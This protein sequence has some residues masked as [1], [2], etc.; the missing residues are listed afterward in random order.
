MVTARVWR[1]RSLDLA[2]VM[3]GVVGLVLVGVL[4]AL[5]VDSGNEPL[6]VLLLFP[7]LGVVYLVTG[8][9]GWR[10]RPH[11]RIGPILVG[12]GILVLMV[13]LGNVETSSLVAV[14]L[15]CATLPLG[16]IVHLLLAFPSGRLTTRASLLIVIA[17]YV[18]C[19]VL[20]APLYL[21]AAPGPVPDDPLAIADRP[22]L[23]E[24][25]RTVQSIA[26]A[27]VMVA[28]ALVLA[29]RLRAAT[30]RQRRVLG[31]LDAYGVVVILAI[32][33]SSLVLSRVGV[34]VVLSVVIQIVLLAGIPLAFTLSIQRGGF[35]PTGEID[36]LAVR[37]GAE[38][39]GRSTVDGA[40]AETLGDPSLQVVFAVADGRPV[41]GSGRSFD[42]DEPG[43][44]RGVSAVHIGSRPVA[45]IVYDATLIREPGYVDS[46]G[47]VAALALERERL[48]AELMVRSRELEQSRVRIIETGDEERRRIAQDLHDG[49]QSQLVLLALRA[50]LLTEVDGASPAVVRRATQLRRELDSAAAELRRLVHGLM[51]ALLVERGLYAATEDL[52]ALTPLPTDLVLEGSDAGLPDTVTS[53]AYFV[54]A[55]GLANAMKHSRAGRMSV[56][57]DRV[58][59]TLRIEV[60]DNGIGGAVTTGGAGLRGLAD[61]I[62]GLGGRLRIDSPPAQGTRI[63]A[64]VPCAP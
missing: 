31:P 6:W 15:V 57:L 13:S 27:L 1:S 9:L 26:G 29:R 53:A 11:N 19:L 4:V 43:P 18:V 3:L 34:D 45:W 58:N 39:A 51:P 41:D 8:L 22:D 62:D 35:A 33:F 5:T 2:L 47:R 54:V 55:E 52:V 7:A 40:L 20:Q 32:P 16:V 61:R 14:G 37:L 64:E 44:G 49:L 50:G 36:A 46:A 42:I 25:G 38:A 17:V 23:M 12:G 28:T 59:G 21:F 30:P 56:G 60:S 63:V 10:R 24:A 48:T